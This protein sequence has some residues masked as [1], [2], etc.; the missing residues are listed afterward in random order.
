MAGD[1]VT[2]I[3]NRFTVPRFGGVLFWQHTLKR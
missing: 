1:L 2:K 3:K